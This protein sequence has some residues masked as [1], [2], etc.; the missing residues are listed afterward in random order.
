MLTYLWKVLF[1]AKGIYGQVA[2]HAFFFVN[3]LF[4]AFARFRSRSAHSNIWQRS[5]HSIHVLVLLQ[6]SHF[7]VSSPLFHLFI[8]FTSRY[9]AGF[10]FL[11]IILFW[12]MHEYLFRFFAD[13]EYE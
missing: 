9:C 13:T 5:V 6:L 2:G 11:F 1:K 8:A 3:F 12:G 10:P 4:V 7:G